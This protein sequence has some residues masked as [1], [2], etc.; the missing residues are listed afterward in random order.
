MKLDCTV[1]PSTANEA[2]SLQSAEDQCFQKGKQVSGPDEATGSEVEK[3][4]CV[5]PSFSW[6][7]LFV[8]H[9]KV[10]AFE[11]QLQKDGLTF[12]I[13]KT[14]R[15]VPRH[16]QKGGVREVERPTVS[17]LIFI[18]GD[19]KATQDYLNVNF[20]AHRLCRNCSTG[21]VATIPCSQMEPFMRI[22]ETDPDRLRFLLHPFIYYSKNRTLLRIVSGSYAGLEGYVIRIARDRKLVLDVGGMAVAIAGVHAERFEEV[23]DSGNNDSEPFYQRNL[24]EREAF[25]DRYFHPVKTAQEVLAQAENIDMLRLRIAKDL[26]L[27]RLDPRDA[28]DTLAF[29]IEEIAYYYV[30]N[31]ENQRDELRPIF[32][33]GTHVMSQIDAILTTV[34]HD[35]DLS[36]RLE[37]HHEELLTKYGYLF[38]DGEPLPT[39]P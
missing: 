14:M 27:K 32:E 17:G 19:A 38:P 4:A 36:Q 31:M 26:R 29:V 30:P 8:H 16:R 12:F 15:Y 5:T 18:Q 23:P 35:T 7:Y 9:K 3:C 11:E 24:Q 13:H 28:F 21:K 10:S 20:P 22:A 25:I 39:L 1:S 37:T 6:C 33:A 2:M 34:N